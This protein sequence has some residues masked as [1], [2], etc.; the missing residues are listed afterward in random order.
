MVFGMK[1]GQIGNHQNATTLSRR[2]C[3]E[4]QNPQLKPTLTVCRQLS[5][6]PPGPP[7]YDDVSGAGR[8]HEGPV[9]DTESTEP[10]IPEFVENFNVRTLF[11]YL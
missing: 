3:F 4:P 8:R 2:F 5:S 1:S 10:W 9:D 11:I 7:G 6:K